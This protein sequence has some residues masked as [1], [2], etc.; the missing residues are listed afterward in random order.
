[1]EDRLLKS[2]KV[3]EM[4]NQMVAILEKVCGY[5]KQKRKGKRDFVDSIVE[6]IEENYSDMNLSVT[7]I[8]EKFDLTPTYLTKLFKEQM[9][10]GIFEFISRVRIE[11]A[12]LLLKSRDGDWNI[13][14]IAEKVGYFNSNV[15]YKGF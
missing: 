15:F 7:V 11:K 5:I 1:M 14:D 9:T 10:E 13:K 6:Y 12:K 8:A 2:G 4:Q 3:H